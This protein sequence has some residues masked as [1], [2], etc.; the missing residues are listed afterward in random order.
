MLRYCYTAAIRSLL[1]VDFHIRS[2]ALLQLL[3]IYVGCTIAL[4]SANLFI[5]LAITQDNSYLLEYAHLVCSQACGG[6]GSLCNS[7]WPLAWAATV[8]NRASTSGQSGAGTH[9]GQSL[10][11]LRCLGLA[12]LCYISLCSL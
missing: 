7:R 8:I 12:P 10:L 9:R 3:V 1:A 2:I 4:Q 11:L 6:E 5:V